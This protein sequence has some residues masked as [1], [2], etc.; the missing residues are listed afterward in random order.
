MV[1]AL[2]FGIPKKFNFSIRWFAANLSNVHEGNASMPTTDTKPAQKKL[3]A[4][5][6]L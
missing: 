6:N 5:K 2:S 4:F 1:L 3:Y